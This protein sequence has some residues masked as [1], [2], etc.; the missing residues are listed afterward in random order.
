[1]DDIKFSKYFEDAYLGFIVIRPIP[2]KVFGFCILKTYRELSVEK[3]FWGIRPYNVNIFGRC[4]SFDALAFQEQDGT[5]SACATTAIW[6]ALSKANHLNYTLLKT[7]NQITKDAG[8]TSNSGSRLFPNKG[9]TISQV[10]TSLVRAGLETEVILAK[11]VNRIKI[12]SEY[13]DKELITI[14]QAKRL[15]DLDSSMHIESMHI[16]RVINAYSR[17]GIP[18]ICTFQPYKDKAL[19]AIAINGFKKVKFDSATSKS[20]KKFHFERIETLYAHDDQWGPYTKIEFDNTKEYG[21][22]TIWTEKLAPAGSSRFISLIIPVYKKVRINYNDTEKIINDL[23]T[24]YATIFKNLKSSIHITY[25]YFV[26]N[27]NEYKAQVNNFLN[28]SDIEKVKFSLT[29]LPRFIWVVKIYINANLAWDLVL[30]ATDVRSNMLGVAKITYGK[31]SR[32]VNQQ[33][34]RLLYKFEEQIRADLTHASVNKDYIYKLIMSNMEYNYSEITQIILTKNFDT[35]VV[36]AYQNKQNLVIAYLEKKDLDDQLS[37]NDIVS[38]LES[39]GLISESISHGAVWIPILWATYSA[40]RHFYKN[41]KGKPMS[42]WS[43]EEKTRFI[44][45]LKTE[46]KETSEGKNTDLSL[47]ED[48][49]QNDK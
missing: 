17:L 26:I 37:D 3:S 5:L 31:N 43:S 2:N 25:D 24:I 27:S 12:L 15:V 41:L 7:P 1:M 28:L 35:E 45:F 36:N 44:N 11:K 16:K 20:I 30:D 38:H 14:E 4:Y 6:V 8:I 47:S 39:F 23:N 42:N 49:I 48:D 19:H 9:L 29:S 34:N 18:I 10:C 40:C 22:D 46:L 32:L 13:T 33:I 21:I